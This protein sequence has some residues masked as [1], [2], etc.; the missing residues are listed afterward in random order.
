MSEAE[1]AAEKLEGHAAAESR[2]NAARVKELAGAL[3]AASAR[4]LSAL[5]EEERTGAASSISVQPSAKS[6]AELAELYRL[7]LCCPGCNNREFCCHDSLMVRQQ[8]AAPCALTSVVLEHDKTGV[9]REG[10]LGR[11]GC[12]EGLRAVLACLALGP[13]VTALPQ[14]HPALR[15]LACHADGCCSDACPQEHL[16]LFH[17]RP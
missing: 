4:A 7:T 2:A 11:G 15:L 5:E 16:D 9:M 14:S 12:G 13:H 6:D 3:A 8:K 1:A 10:G 17:R